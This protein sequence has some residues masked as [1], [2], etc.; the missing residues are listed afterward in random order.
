MVKIRKEKRKT[1][2]L[3]MPSLARKSFR[4]AGT[5]H[6][7]TTYYVNQMTVF[8]RLMYYSIPQQSW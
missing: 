4:K 7:S 1:V 3:T 5:N 8:Q 6:S 2:G